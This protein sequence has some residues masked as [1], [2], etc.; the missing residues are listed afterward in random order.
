[1]GTLQLTI[2]VSTLFWLSIIVHTVL[3]SVLLV[4]VASEHNKRNS[5]LIFPLIA[6]GVLFLIIFLIIV[7]YYPPSNLLLFGTIL[8][9]SVIIAFVFALEIPGF[10]LISRHDQKVVNGLSKVRSTLVPLK[11]AF[12]KTYVKFK[13]AFSTNEEH[14]KETNLFD[15]VYDFIKYC[16]QLKNLN[17]K[18]W[19]LLLTEL[20]RTIEVYNKRSKHPYPKLIE[21]LS[22]TGLSFLIAQFLHI[23]V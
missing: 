1:M 12:S 6:E 11:Y 4:F 7:H 16:N 22:L 21:V 17:E 23:L 20:T 9:Y 14:L 8:V 18:F 5:L 13:D 19:E 2:D 15:L 10:I 3:I